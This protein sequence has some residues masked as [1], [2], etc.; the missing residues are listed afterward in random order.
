MQGQNKERWKVLCEQTAVEQDPQK[1]LAL[2][3]EINDLLLGKQRRLDGEAP[4]H[5]PKGSDV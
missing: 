2:T 1:L 5:K 4:T 3:K